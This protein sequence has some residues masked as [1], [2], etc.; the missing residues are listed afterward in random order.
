MDRSGRRDPSL[1]WTWWGVRGPYPADGEAEF[2]GEGGSPAALSCLHPPRTG[3]RGPERWRLRAGGREGGQLGSPP[4][5]TG[6]QQKQEALADWRL[7]P[8]LYLL[9]VPSEDP[10]VGGTGPQSC[11]ET[12]SLLGLLPPS[13][14]SPRG[15]LEPW[16]LCSAGGPRACGLGPAGQRSGQRGSL[17]C[18]RP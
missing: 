16:P 10:R 5:G 18:L 8:R 1:R 2:R 9:P 11:R 13:M 6:S 12:P 15:R 17:G 4:P 14:P 3:L 7:T